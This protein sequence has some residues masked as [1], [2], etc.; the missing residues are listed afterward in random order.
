VDPQRAVQERSNV[1]GPST[2][3]NNQLIPRQSLS[4]QGLMVVLSYVIGIK[5]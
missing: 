3:G 2:P 4:L 5:K 1:K